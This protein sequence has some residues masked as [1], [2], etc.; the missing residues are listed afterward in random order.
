MRKSIVGK[1]RLLQLAKKETITSTISPS[2]SN[3]NN[4]TQITNNIQ[5]NIS[6]TNSSSEG[7]SDSCY[8]PY[9]SSGEN[10]EQPSDFNSSR[11]SKKSTS[12]STL[13][14][15][16]QWS[17]DHS[18]NHSQLSA[19]LE[20][21][22]LHD[23]FSSF[24]CDSRTVVK[25]AKFNVSIES[26]EPGEYIHFGVQP[27]LD[28]VKKCFVCDAPAKSFIKAIKGHNGY[29]G[30]DKC[31]VVGKNIN[32]RMSYFDINSRTRTDAQFRARRDED[33]HTSAT[34]LIDIPNLD[35]INAFPIDYMHLVCLGVVKKLLKLWVKGKPGEN[36]LSHHQVSQISSKLIQ[37]RQLTPSEFSRSPRSFD[38]LDRWKA[39]EFR[40][41]LLYSGQIVLKN[42]ISENN[43]KL[44]LSLS[45]AI[46]ILCSKQHYQSHNNFAKSLLIYFVQVFKVLYGED[47]V[48]YNIH[49]LVHLA[50]DS[51]KFGVLD[52]F[53]AF[54]FE[55]K[56][57][58]L[59]KLIRTPNRPLQ[60]LKRRLLEKDLK[61]E[62]NTPAV[63]GLSSSHSNNPTKEKD[64]AS[65]VQFQVY[66][67]HQFIINCR[68]PRDTFVLTE[69]KLLFKVKNIIKN[70][71][72]DSVFLVGHKFNHLHSIF[73]EPCSSKEINIFCTSESDFEISRI[74]V[75]D[76]QYKC[77]VFS[78]S[79]GRLAIIPLVHL[80]L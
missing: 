72:N 74:C 25:L 20:I 80:Y 77:Q 33:H 21:L 57:G 79:S 12:V 45:V 29:H 15:I 43:Y 28:Q 26:I 30:C 48:S 40:H 18:V 71:N 70:K 68:L 23:C 65:F 49:G 59:R 38:E 69:D 16:K 47:K 62:L 22:R 9:C 51:L 36:K 50:D 13:D 58:T 2:S 41:F 8:S 67:T 61:L 37:S 10:E 39:T 75:S 55:N 78:I 32:R 3:T 54:K 1:R 44:F 5:N 4:T 31:C 14:Q 11:N 53:S 6:S 76:I 27:Y 73:N 35:L 60:Q 34:A 7:E 56:L 46:R 63:V 52:K 24:P 66:S 19:L 17:F 64:I 42:I